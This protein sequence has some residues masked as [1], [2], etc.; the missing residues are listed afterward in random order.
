MAH[1]RGGQEKGNQWY[2]D[3]RKLKKKNSMFDLI[4]C[5]EYLISNGYSKKELMAGE[6]ILL[7]FCECIYLFIIFL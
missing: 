6:S 2:F 1:V 4:S 7:I 3:G 5:A